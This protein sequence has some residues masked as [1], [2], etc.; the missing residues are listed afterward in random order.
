M[1]AHRCDLT[2]EHGEYH[3]GDS[4]EL[5]RSLPDAS[6]DAVICSPP[7]EGDALIA[8]AGRTGEA[9]VEWLSPFFAEFER[10]LRPGGR[11]A[12]ELGGL[13]LTDAAG[14][15][16]QHAAALRALAASGWRLL[17]DFFYF[18]PQLLRPQPGLGGRVADSVTPIWVV[19]R[20]YDGYYD[21]AVPDREPHRG[22]VRGNLLEFDNSG[23]Y[24][25]AYE[26]ALAQKGIEPYVDRWPSAVPAFFVDLLTPVGGYVLDPFAGTG[27]T[28][29]AAERQGRRWTGCERDRGLEPH[30][31]A[32]FGEGR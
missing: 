30:V 4:L 18:N 29:H 13:W 21:T 1:P 7:F 12:F 16:V 28:C 5:M 22:F 17:Q 9:F 32:M 24:D 6:V 14:K 25:Q 10:L 31:R 23:E 8:D 11:V 26:K 19:A 3:W 27:A 2:A 15:S 20:E